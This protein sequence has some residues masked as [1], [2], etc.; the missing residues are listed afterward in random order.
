MPDLAEDVLPPR[1]G[2][3]PKPTGEPPKKRGRPPGTKNKPK[4]P[5]NLEGDLRD[6]LTEF[7]A[8]PIS[9]VSPI[10]AKVF[11]QRQDRTIRAIVV[12]AS[13]NPQFAKALATF[14][15]G[16]AYFDLVGTVVGM[17]I[18]FAVDHGQVEANS[19]PAMVFHIDEIV[20][21][22]YPQD[23]ATETANGNGNLV[24]DRGLLGEIG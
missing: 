19:M 7:V 3:A 6:K 2:E 16:S 21:E 8:L 14:L 5:E 20:M 22:L 1:E 11:E 17:G 10:A 13:K 4:L 12:I 9:F 23:A 18:G 24:H 15:E